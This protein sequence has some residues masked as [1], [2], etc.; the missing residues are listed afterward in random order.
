MEKPLVIFLMGKAQSGKDTLADIMTEEIEYRYSGNYPV[1]SLAFADTLKNLCARNHGYLDKKEHRDVLINIG[2]E[3][4]RIDRDAFVKPVAYY[5]NIYREMGY[6]VF[7][8]T[9]LRYENEYESLIKLVDCV[10]FTI[11]V[12]GVYEHK[13]I[14][15]FAKNHPTE[16]LNFTPDYNIVLPPL[17]KDTAIQAEKEILQILQ[18][19]FDRYRDEVLQ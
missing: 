11:R 5:I 10:P 6:K 8:I 2:D 17:N 14:S 9:D 15:I 4:R 1:A 16:N 18:N 13:N 19:I 12:Q 7:I 3:M